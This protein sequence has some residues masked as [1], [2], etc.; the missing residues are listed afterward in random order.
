MRGGLGEVGG[1]VAAVQNTAKHLGVQRFDAPAEYFGEAGE[2][3]LR[4]LLL[5]TFFFQEFL[6]TTSRVQRDAVA[7][8]APSHQRR[9]T[10]FVVH[11]KQGGTNWTSVGHERKVCFLQMKTSEHYCR[12]KGT[13]PARRHS[14]ESPGTRQ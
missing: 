13:A 5:R 3:L 7:A 4:R 12:R 6:G 1:L 8:S 11:G 2:S 14:R 10:V 9:Q